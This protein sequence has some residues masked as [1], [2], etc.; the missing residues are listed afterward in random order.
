MVKRVQ[1]VELEHYRQMAERQCRSTFN[2]P[3]ER[4]RACKSL[5]RLVK[6]LET[7]KATGRQRD[8]VRLA[9]YKLDRCRVDSGERLRLYGLKRRGR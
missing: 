4:E 3:S 7:G 5:K 9:M 2:C 8:A 1:T 6:G